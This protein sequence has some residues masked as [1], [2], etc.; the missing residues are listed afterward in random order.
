ME[1]KVEKKKG[2]KVGKKKFPETSV[3]EKQIQKKEK[4]RKKKEM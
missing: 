4:G 3:M 2:R 1:E